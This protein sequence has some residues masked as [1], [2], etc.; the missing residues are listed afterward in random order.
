M[1]VCR[2]FGP[3]SA[4]RASLPWL[5]GGSTQRPWDLEGSQVIFPE[6]WRLTESYRQM[7]PSREPC[8]WWSW[9]AAKAVTWGGSGAPALC[10]PAELLHTHA[11]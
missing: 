3:S 9:L 5:R 7:R 4:S 2:V 11:C 8:C 6:R 1:W 10:W